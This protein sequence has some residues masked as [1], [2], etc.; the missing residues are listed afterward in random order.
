MRPLF[1][2]QQGTITITIGVVA[3]LCI[4]A[5][6]VSK[7]K[8]KQRG[9]SKKET[10]PVS[11]PNTQI[12]ATTLGVNEDPTSSDGEVIQIVE[13][14][15]AQEADNDEEASIKTEYARSDERSERPMSRI[16]SQSVKSSSSNVAAKDEQSINLA[17]VTGFELVRR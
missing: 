13:N 4:I 11:N 5:L 8:R 7:Y 6:L 9:R 17:S 10:L 2:Q 1:F 14:M 15:K 12:F 3:T 16:S